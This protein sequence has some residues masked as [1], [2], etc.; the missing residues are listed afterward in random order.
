MKKV[1]NISVKEFLDLQKKEKV[2]LIDIR[3][4][5]EHSL[6]CIDCAENI[7]VEHIY[8]ADIKEDEVV[9]LH[10]QFGGRTNQAASKVA[11][12]NAKNIYLLDGG[13]TAWKQHKQPTVKN[14]K[15]PL[16][17]MR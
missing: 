3:S 12:L 17:I 6:E 4:P 5:Q 8:D 15:E 2:K 9:V 1:K 14:T 13:I 16:P 11:G 7:L 10:C